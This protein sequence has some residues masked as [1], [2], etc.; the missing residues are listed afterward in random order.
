MI[1]FRGSP[2]ELSDFLSKTFTKKTKRGLDLTVEIVVPNL[3][4]AEPIDAHAIAAARPYML[5]G[6]KI[7]A[8]K[9][10]RE[11]TGMGLA[12]AKAFVEARSWS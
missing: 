2:K 6:Q 3:Q 8:I 1:R 12:E 11:I 10:V 4:K 7:L 5:I 9:A